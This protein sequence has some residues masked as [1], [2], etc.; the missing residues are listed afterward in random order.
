MSGINTDSV[1][2]VMV[3]LEDHRLIYCVK[4]DA[5]FRSFVQADEYT[6]ECGKNI[7][8]IKDPECQLLHEC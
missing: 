2:L 1:H 7:K 6:T 8:H 4:C 3:D 5:W